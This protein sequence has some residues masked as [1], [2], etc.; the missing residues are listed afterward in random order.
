MDSL[1]LSPGW[2]VEIESSYLSWGFPGCP[3][4]KVLASNTGSA[5]SVPDLGTQSPYTKGQG[6]PKRSYL[7]S[8]G[9]FPHLEN[10]DNNSISLKAPSAED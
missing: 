7:S 9:P 5:D 10:G 4:V 8:L 1:G 2:G 6:P 3:V